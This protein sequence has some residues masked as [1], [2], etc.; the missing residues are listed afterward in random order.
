MTGEVSCASVTLPMS[1][2]DE[3]ALTLAPNPHYQYIMLSFFESIY[4]GAVHQYTLGEE[5][6]GSKTFPRLMHKV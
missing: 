2:I 5:F 6:T 3:A 1:Y 4:Q